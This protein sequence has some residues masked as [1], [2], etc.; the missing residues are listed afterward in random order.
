MKIV[1]IWMLD[2]RSPCHRQPY[3]SH[4]GE[5]EEQLEAAK[6]ESQSASACAS[7]LLLAGRIAWEAAAII[8]R[9]PAVRPVKASEA[10]ESLRETRWN[11][12]IDLDALRASAERVDEGTW[13]EAIKDT[14]DLSS[15][16][17]LVEQWD[18]EVLETGIVREEFGGKR[19]PSVSW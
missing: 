3:S 17:E 13:Y 8:E 16:M 11:S 10:W 4:S 15:V 2:E 18:E 12:Y 5:T 9:H 14:I 6:A 19:T 7:C 1:D